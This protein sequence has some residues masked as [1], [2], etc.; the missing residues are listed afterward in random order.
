M[1][2][3]GDVVGNRYRVHSV[4]GRGGFGAVY[5]AED[6]TL[7]RRVA[8]KHCWPQPQEDPASAAADFLKEAQVL[9]GVRHPGLCAVLDFVVDAG[10]RYLA[11]ELVPGESL[12]D[13]V[14]RR[15][16]MDPAELQSVLRQTLE[17]LDHLHTGCRP[18]VVHRDFKPANLR[19]DPSG[20]VVLVDFGLARPRRPG[21]RDTQILGTPGFA[22]PEQYQGLSQPGSDLYAWACTIF[23]LATGHYPQST[24]P[25]FP[26]L[27]SLRPDLPSALEEVLEACK[28]PTP[29]RR[30]TARQ[31]LRHLEGGRFYQPG[32]PS[33]TPSGCPH[34]GDGRP[35]LARRCPNCLLSPDLFGAP[36][37]AWLARGQQY[38]AGHCHLE[39][40]AHFAKARSLGWTGADLDL[41]EAR[42]LER[43][44]R[45]AEAL[46][47]LQNLPDCGQ[48]RLER[49]RCLARL[50]RVEEARALLATE[51]GLETR[52]LHILLSGG[53]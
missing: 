35:P 50:G 11:M 26:P 31:A 16:R 25:P 1:K 36:A 49:A 18:P 10:E 42:A 2:R 15:G 40:A 23:Y 7:G 37:A 30:P 43:S 22:A 33:T 29:E 13:Y 32:A 12:E 34:C 53:P 28:D 3:A 19:R 17:A 4:L 9:Q 39:A 44:G 48:V 8:L 45:P 14:Q 5:E 52:V 27:R 51:S 47:L 38:A 20:R 46:R 41:A 6:L 24:P 21:Q